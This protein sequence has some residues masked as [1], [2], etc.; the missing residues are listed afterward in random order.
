[1]S[2]RDDDNIEGFNAE[3][4]GEQNRESSLKFPRVPLLDEHGQPTGD[5]ITPDQYN[6]DEHKDR[7]G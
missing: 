6:D 3:A 1:M 2:D 7:I 4:Y 5:S